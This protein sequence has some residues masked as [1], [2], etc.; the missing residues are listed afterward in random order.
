MTI[1][2]KQAII[3]YL[4]GI[5]E[6]ADGSARSIRQDRRR[7]AFRLQHRRG[8]FYR[9]AAQCLRRSERRQGRRPRRRR[10]GPRLRLCAQRAGRAVTIFARTPEQGRKFRR[11]I[12]GSAESVRTPTGL[13]R[14]FTEDF[15]ILVNT[16]PLG[17]EGKTA[18]RTP[19]TAEQLKGLQLVYDLV[20][21][22]FQTRLM[23]RPTSGS[24]PKIGGLAMLIA[25]AVEQ[26][27][28]WTGL[29]AP[30]REMS[31]AALERLQ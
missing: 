9:A 30:M 14:V 7:Q 20:Y 29:D 8:R 3:R 11:R 31:R 13:S 15:D 2:H 10:R 25:Q 27:R 16:T 6:T 1:P 28:I 4:D 22:P 23:A 5:D 24:V 18:D 12:Q 26:Q 19:A 21:T 17:M